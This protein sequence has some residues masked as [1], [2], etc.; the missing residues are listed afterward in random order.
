M[1]RRREGQQ[2]FLLGVAVEP[3]NRAQPTRD[4][5]PGPTALLQGAGVALDVNPAHREQRQVMVFAP[6]DE[7]EQIEGAG[8]AGRSPV[9]GQ[10]A[11]QVQSLAIT[12]ARVVEDHRRERFVLHG[13]PPESVGLEGP[14]PHG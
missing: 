5:C 3:G 9:A 4:R 6:G 11:G 10:E 8:V 12:E 13:L 7:L 2:T 14:E 1:H